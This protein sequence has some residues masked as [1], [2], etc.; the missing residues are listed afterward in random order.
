LSIQCASEYFCRTSRCLMSL[1]NDFEVGVINNACKSN[2]GQSWGVIKTFFCHHDSICNIF[3]CLHQEMMK[4][5]IVNPPYRPYF[6]DYPSQVIFRSLPV[7]EIPGGSGNSQ[8]CD[9]NFAHVDS[10]SGFTRIFTFHE[11][12][13]A[14]RDSDKRNPYMTKFSV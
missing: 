11:N 3:T 7:S 12:T 8:S 14:T 10:P 2:K 4:G 5:K 1:R 9:A 6:H 13:H